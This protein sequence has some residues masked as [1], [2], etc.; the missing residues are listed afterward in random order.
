MRRLQGLVVAV[1]ATMAGLG[2][3][4]PADLPEDFSW[5][6]GWTE[7]YP[8]HRV[9]GNLYA[10]GMAD[11]SVFL[12]TSDEGHILINTGLED[13]TR[14]IRANMAALGFQLED[15]QILL[16]TQSHFDHAAALAEIKQLSGARMLVKRIRPPSGE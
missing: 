16:C 2:S 3:A 13:S 6:P 7:P 12:I 8:A 1:L 14:H 15:V 10:V 5:P 9:I 4:Q 11:L